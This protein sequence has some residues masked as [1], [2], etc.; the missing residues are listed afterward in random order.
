MKALFIYSIPQ[1]SDWYIVITD[2]SNHFYFNSK[3]GNAYWQLSDLVGKYGIIIEQFFASVNFDQL[4]LLFA[5]SRGLKLPKREKY[6]ESN[7][8]RSD[9]VRRDQKDVPDEVEIVYENE[10]ISNDNNDVNEGPNSGNKSSQ[11]APSPVKGIVSGYSSS[12]EEVEEEEDV[13]DRASEEA[14]QQVLEEDEIGVDALVSQVLEQRGVEDEQSDNESQVSLDLSVDDEPDQ[15]ASA[16]QEF[17]EML[18]NYSSQIS[19]FDSWDIIEDQLV[20]EFIKYPIYHSI[21]SRREKAEIF[22]N[23]V[24]SREDEEE[25]FPTGHDSEKIFPTQKI[26]FLSLLQQ[27][28]DQVK[29]S[30]Y[31]EFYTSHYKEINNIDIPKSTKEE[32]YR[33]YKKFIQD[34]AKFEKDYKKTAE[35]KKGVNVKVMKLKE[36]LSSQQN[37]P[38]GSFAI[39]PESSFFEN[40]VDLLNQ[41]FK[42]D[43]TVAEAEIN[44]LLGDEKRLSSYIAKLNES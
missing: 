30:F 25:S 23:W 31:Q 33:N 20:K 2:T 36:Y 21:G 1:S 43:T 34:F 32:T 9:L 22:Q 4:G 5:K 7:V 44:F 18:N 40:W 28:K 42:D 39:N 19:S 38:K 16:I 3:D 35:Y 24:D 37:F 13:T 15:K 27:H 17:E 14:R 8:S 10:Y 29:S 6:D 26:L 41:F 12:E 11:S